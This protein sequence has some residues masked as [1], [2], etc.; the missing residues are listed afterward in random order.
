M[1]EILI[2]VILTIALIIS[3]LYIILIKSQMKKT[4]KELKSSREEGYNKLLTA[5]L[6]D[7]DQEKLLYEINKNLEY[8]NIKKIQAEGE[9]TKL[10]QS[11]SDI[12][13][14]L[15]TPV[16]VIR[17]N[18]QMIEKAGVL[19]DEEADELRICLEKS[20]DLKMM[21]DEFYELSYFESE[22][23]VLSTEHIDITDFVANFI[24]DNEALL[25]K[26]E[27]EPVV[28]LP[29]K[30]IFIDADPAL[31]RR[32]LSNLLTNVLRY[33]KEYLRIEVKENAGFAEISMENESSGGN[34][35]V[36]R[37][38]D[39]TYRADKVR[40]NGGPGGLGLYIVKILSEKMNGKVFAQSENNVF[41][42]GVSFEIQ[43]IQR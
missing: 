11:I 15:R 38:F 35:D 20:N 21:V 9:R 34:I 31:L 2:I 5:E 33:S 32:V 26:K 4:R 28:M 43:N 25:R 40:T 30:S 12:A 3:V 13:H 18:L 39:R 24:I 7:K 10:K 14:D 8:Q 1:T 23:V 27:Y 42:I 19:R 17:G 6:V 16:T 22:D 41:R 29:D 36:E 37:I